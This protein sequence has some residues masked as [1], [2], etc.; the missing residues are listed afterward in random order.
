LQNLFC[1]LEEIGGLKWTA[2]ADV[3]GELVEQD[4]VILAV[5]D[6]VGEVLDSV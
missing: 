5:L 6:V 4:S 1:A 2:G 3:W